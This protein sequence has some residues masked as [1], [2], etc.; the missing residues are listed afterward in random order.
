MRPRD[1]LVRLGGAALLTIAVVIAPAPTSAQK[2]GGT[3]RIYHFDSPPSLP[4]PR[5]VSHPDQVRPL[6]RTSLA[7]RAGAAST[8]DAA[9]R[10]SNIVRSRYRLFS[11]P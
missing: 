11:F 4:F 7:D 5:Q 2:Q 8:S 6:C 3:L 9:R 10:N 1:L